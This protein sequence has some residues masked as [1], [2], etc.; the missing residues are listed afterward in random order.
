MTVSAPSY[1]V[2]LCLHY[3]LRPHYYPARTAVVHVH[4]F[5]LQSRTAKTSSAAGSE[6]STPPGDAARSDM[7]L[8]VHS[9]DLRARSSAVIVET[10]GHITDTVIRVG[11]SLCPL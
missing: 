11:C 8:Q 6:R 10:G 3:C 7:Q 4:P 1:T 5:C 2:T 9:C